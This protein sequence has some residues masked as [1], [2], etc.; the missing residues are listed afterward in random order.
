MRNAVIALG[1]LLMLAPAG[2]GGKEDQAKLSAERTKALKDDV[3][4]FILTLRYR[5]PEDKP[6][7]WLTLCRRMQAT[8]AVYQF[9]L[10][11]L[12]DRDTTL[13]VIDWLAESGVLAAA[14]DISIEEKPRKQPQG[15]CY[16]AFASGGKMALMHDLGWGPDLAKRL[17]SLRA[18]LTGD[19][20]KQMDVF[21]GRLGGYFKEWTGKPYEPPK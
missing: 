21:L 12:I 6:F 5:G 13:K 1:V 11:G 10:T 15:P 8:T 4:N 2:V 7:Y 20:A 9:E 17:L 3:E 19:A 16:V 18:L 14:E